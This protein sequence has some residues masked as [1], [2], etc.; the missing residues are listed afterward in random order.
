[1]VQRDRV[2]HVR[3]DGKTSDAIRCNATESAKS[4]RFRCTISNWQVVS[5]MNVN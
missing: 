5:Q 2:I 3:D 1:M 4:P